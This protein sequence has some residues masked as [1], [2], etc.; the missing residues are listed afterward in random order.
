MEVDCRWPCQQRR[1]GVSVSQD[2]QL[3]EWLDRQA[4]QDLIHRYSDSVTRGDHE[5]TATVF[6]PDAVWEKESGARVESA[7][8]FI[9]SVIEGTA[10]L[11]TASLDPAHPDAA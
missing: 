11:D 10:S 3:E 2:W 1:P 9:D 8:E 7:R 5:Q 4:I 6:A